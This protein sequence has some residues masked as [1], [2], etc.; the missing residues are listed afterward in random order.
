ML[1]KRKVLKENLGGT[2]DV[3]NEDGGVMALDGKVLPLFFRIYSFFVA[4][5]SASA[6]SK[7]VEHA[8]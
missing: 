3:M 2:G 1:Q 5:G 4:A 6:F 8:Y 7:A